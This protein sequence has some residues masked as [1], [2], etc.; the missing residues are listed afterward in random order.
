MSGPREQVGAAEKGALAE[1]PRQIPW[2]GWKPILQRA[3]VNSGRHNLSLLSAGVAFYAFLSF[4]PLLGS[5]VMTYEPRRVCR[6]HEVVSYAAISML[7]A[8]A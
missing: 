1:T 3:W 5:L 2:A 4:V 6:R 8:A 7:S